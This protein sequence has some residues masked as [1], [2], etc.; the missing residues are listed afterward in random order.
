[1]TI[2]DNGEGIPPE[3]IDSIFEIFA[4]TKGSRGTGLGLPVSLKIVREHGGK[5][6]VASE[7]GH[8]STFTVEL[9]LKRFDSKE[10]DILQT[11]G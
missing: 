4:S 6:V 9:P 5:I 10:H 1:V 3:E 8:G 11:M 2:T 7:P